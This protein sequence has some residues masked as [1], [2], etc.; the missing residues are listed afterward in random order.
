R[1]STTIKLRAS[2]GTRAPEVSWPYAGAAPRLAVGWLPGISPG[3]AEPR[4]PHLRGAG[5]HRQHAVARLRAGDDAVDPGGRLAPVD[6]RGLRASGHRAQ[7]RG[8]A[9]HPLRRA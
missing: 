8:G 3:E 4:D 5:V 2:S 9:S 6:A 7:A 1:A